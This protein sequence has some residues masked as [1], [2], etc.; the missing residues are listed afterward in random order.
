MT[1]T[2][3]RW[4]QQAERTL[5]AIEA[6]RLR[7]AT[8][9]PELR[10]TVAPP[11]THDKNCPYE[12]ENYDPR[13]VPADPYSS[14]TKHAQPSSPYETPGYSPT[15]QPADGYAIGLAKKGTK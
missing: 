4:L 6:H 11:C 12:T 3:Q 1:K 2:T 15:G 14:V 7:T 9:A 8:G 5:R 13:G 10:T